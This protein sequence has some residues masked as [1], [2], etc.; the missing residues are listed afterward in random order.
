[1]LINIP[2][3]T[4]CCECEFCSYENGE[5]FLKS[6]IEGR[7]YYTI[8][9]GSWKDEKSRPKWCPFIVPEKQEE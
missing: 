3:K 2:E 5:C 1:M 6:A 9:Y 7:S 8:G 4:N